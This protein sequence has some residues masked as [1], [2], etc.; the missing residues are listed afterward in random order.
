MAKGCFRIVDYEEGGPVKSRDSANVRLVCLTDANERLVIWGEEGSDRR[1]IDRVLV[2]GLPCQIECD[3]IEPS[4]TLK[5]KFGHKY[6][7][8]QGAKLEV[9]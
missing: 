4:E 6:W 3:Y 2:A 8:P 9:V 7:I 5:D 1:N